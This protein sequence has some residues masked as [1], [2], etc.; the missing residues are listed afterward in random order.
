[1]KNILSFAV[2]ILLVLPLRAQFQPSTLP[3]ILIPGSNVP[4]VH[5][6]RVTCHSYGEVGAFPNGSC[7]LYVSTSLYPYPV[8]FHYKRTESN[9]PANVLD[10]GMVAVPDAENI[11]G[12]VIINSVNPTSPYEVGV[13]V[14]YSL[15]P[16]AGGGGEIAFYDWT[17]AGLNLYQTVT[18]TL[19]PI[20]S[21]RMDAM[22][23]SYYTVVYT[24]TGNTAMYAF[25]GAVNGFYPLVGA[26]KQIN[27]AAPAG[28]GGFLPDVAMTKLTNPPPNMSNTALKN[29]VAFISQD[30]ENCYVYSFGFDELMTSPSP[31]A[32]MYEHTVQQLNLIGANSNGCITNPSNLLPLYYS[33]FGPIVD[34]PD[35]SDDSWSI[36]VEQ[37]EVY[38]N[39]GNDCP[40]PANPLLQLQVSAAY[41]I[42]GGVPQ[43]IVL[44]DGSIP[45]TVDM[46]K[47]T[48]YPFTNTLR[49]S[50]PAVAFSSDNPDLE[51]YIVYGW[52][53]TQENGFLDPYDYMGMT[54]DPMVNLPVTAPGGAPYRIIDYNP[55][56]T[57]Y[58]SAVAFSGQNTTI[59]DLYTVFIS[60]T[61]NSSTSYQSECLYQKHPVWTDI[62]NSGLKPAPA[63]IGE[64]QDNPLQLRVQPNPFGD[65]FT[66]SVSEAHQN[67]E[68]EIWLTDVLGRQ[69]IHGKGRIEA[70]N[71]S[72]RK[73]LRGQALLSGFYFLKV[74]SL[75]TQQEM[76]FKLVKQ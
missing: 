71:A 54:Y 8:S 37:E 11:F 52:G 7:D 55:A 32:M 34:A 26:V 59:N 49:R 24:T 63:A 23:L 56:I 73:D 64:L 12:A 58:V 14:V 66:L 33:S 3:E 2:A 10:E 28:S 67:D 48:A 60:D 72:I 44:N 46:S 27:S 30:K 21:M 51:Q 13:A 5:L 1:M 36:I 15:A 41:K 35:Y 76:N 39:L 9:T 61:S 45:G 16:S 20:S 50:Q 74:H 40:F 4:G 42:N 18:F 47:N 53:K 43:D 65:N 69:I 31:I 75:T 62:L 68:F 22:G 70:L 29:Y 6:H 17:P 19:D 38:N 25:G 57:P